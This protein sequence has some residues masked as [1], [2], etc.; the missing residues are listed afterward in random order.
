[1]TEGCENVTTCYINY[2]DCI[3]NDLTDKYEYT[4][5]GE[6]SDEEIVAAVKK[7]KHIKIAGWVRC[8]C[9]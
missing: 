3:A 5:N 9:K 6:I 1:M 2:L 7:L 4:L 8:Y